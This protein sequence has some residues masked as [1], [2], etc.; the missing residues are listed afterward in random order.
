MSYPKQYESLYRAS[1]ETLTAHGIEPALAV[2]ASEIIARDM[3]N[4]ERSQHDQEL[5]NQVTAK[6]NG[7]TIEQYQ[8]AIAKEAA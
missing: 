8:A 3:A 2:Q 7:M 6:L 5:I 1:L 4:I